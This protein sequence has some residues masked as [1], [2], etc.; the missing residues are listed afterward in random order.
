MTKRHGFGI[1]YVLTLLIAATGLLIAAVVHLSWQRTADSNIRD[2]ASQLNRQIV[3]SIRQ[4]LA[5]TLANAEAAR[6][7]IRSIFY[8]NVLDTTDEAKRE[9]IFLALLQSQPTLSWIS[10][11][12]PNGDFFGSQKLGR[13]QIRMVEVRRDPE[14]HVRQ[15]RIDSYDVLDGDIEFKRRDFT[16]SGFSATDQPWY[17]KSVD[18]EGPV[19]TETTDSPTRIRP[20]VTTSSRPSMTLRKVRATATMSQTWGESRRDWTPHARRASISARAE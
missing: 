4:E 8:Q 18:A 5:A 1:G 11:G 19:W 3:G 6:E 7:A 15:R 14:T 12:W 16:D 17:R 20:A 2:V 13:D 10:F 9:F